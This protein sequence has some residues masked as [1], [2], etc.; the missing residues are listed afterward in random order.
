MEGAVG[1]PVVTDVARDAGGSSSA[2]RATAPVRCRP[3]RAGF[4]DSHRS[5]VQRAARHALEACDALVHGRVGGE[6]ALFPDRMKKL[7]DCVDEFETGDFFHPID[8][9]VRARMVRATR[10]L[11]N[12][13]TDTGM[14]NFTF[15]EDN[16]EN[17]DAK[18]ITPGITGAAIRLSEQTAFSMEQE[19]LGWNEGI[20]EIK[21]FCSELEG[22]MMAPGRTADDIDTK[23]RA[24]TRAIGSVFNTQDSESRNA[25]TRVVS[26]PAGSTRRALERLL[27]RVGGATDESNRSRPKTKRYTVKQ[28]TSLFSI[29]SEVNQPVSAL[30]EIN[31]QRIEDPFN[32]E[33][34]EYRIYER[35]P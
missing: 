13:D 35:W 1:A 22:L 27:D 20:E 7:L 6:E 2:S 10:T 33:P 28:K 14:V 23:A 5:A 16:E 17:I 34:G 21:E 24:V 8:G 26:P 19:D 32:V 31:S 30:A 3:G 15:V 25:S 4:V 11:P 29:A 9:Q 12:E 18:A